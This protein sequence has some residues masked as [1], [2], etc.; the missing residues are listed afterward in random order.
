MLSYKEF[1]DDAISNYRSLPIETNELYK[2]Y[3]VDIS[4]DSGGE[5]HIADINK[6]ESILEELS[7]SVTEKTRIKFDIIV[8]EH[9]I[10]CFN[11]NVRIEKPEGLDP[12]FLTNKLM[13]SGEDK[14]AAYSNANSKY[15]VFIDAKEGKSE[16]LNVLFI[17]KGNLPVQVIVNA[18]K[19][20][21]LEIFE[22][23]L[24]DSKGSGVVS[25][26]HE[27]TGGAN[28]NV[29]LSVL[30]NESE[31]TNVLNLCKAV[32]HDGSRLKAN[33]IYNGGLLS[34]ARNVVDSSG[35]NSHVEITELA[36]GAADQRFDIATSIENSKPSSTALLES[37]TILDGRSQCML[38]GFAK[39]DKDTKGCLSRIT[40]RGIL[41]SKDAHI[42]ALPDMSIDYSNDV[43]ATHSAA[44]SPI[45]EEVLFYLQSRGLEESVAR[46]VFITAFIA[47]YISK[48]GSGIASEVAMSIMLEKLENGSFGV[49]PDITAKGVWMA[50]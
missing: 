27:I 36:F 11:E 24:S 40:E 49:M 13:K 46:K 29:E 41:L 32:A 14:L 39:I 30:H 2:K 17:N 3:F 8:S 33:F 42:D 21:K 25:T 37:G 26:M 12:N 15:F 20:S 34:K 23:Y 10:K 31:K 43:K 44:T 18:A 28:S 38:K 4:L 35:V 9:V 45:D 19:G 47:K 7:K 6:E 22:L 5:I 1:L 50:R 16:R 48:M